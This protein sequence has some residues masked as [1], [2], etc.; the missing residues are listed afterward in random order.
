MDMFRLWHYRNEVEYVFCHFETV[1]LLHD[2][3]VFKQNVS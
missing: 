2:F 3:T 1:F